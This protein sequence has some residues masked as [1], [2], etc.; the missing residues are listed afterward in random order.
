MH[1]GF[2]LRVAGIRPAK[3]SSFNEAVY[4]LNQIT[5]VFWPSRP[6]DF[7]KGLNDPVLVNRLPLWFNPEHPYAKL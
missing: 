1:G 3:H 4:N 6:F 2:W 5:G 7:L